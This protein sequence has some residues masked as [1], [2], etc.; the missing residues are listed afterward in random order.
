M[1]IAMSWT[2]IIC[3]LFLLYREAKKSNTSSFI[4]IYIYITLHHLYLVIRWR[5]L[6]SCW[7]LTKNRQ[8]TWILSVPPTL[9]N[10][11]FNCTVQSK[12]MRRK[13]LQN[14]SNFYL[15]FFFFEGGEDSFSQDIQLTG[16]VI[17]LYC[18][19]K[20]IQ[21]ECIKLLPLVHT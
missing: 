7:Y 17:F 20:R 14:R 16:Y 9:E 21:N 4:Y 1:R 12:W 18:K 5:C 8:Q 6:I 10:A 13:H 3:R 15:R 19:G 2:L 11:I